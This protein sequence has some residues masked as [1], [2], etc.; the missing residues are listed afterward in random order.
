MTI[1]AP[2]SSDAQPLRAHLL[3]S[4]RL[5]VGD[6][7]V[8]D[9]VWSRRAARSLLLLLLV[10]PGHRLPRDR[11]LEL[12]WPDASPDSADQSLRTA[13]HLLRRV[14]QPALRSGR[15][16]VYLAVNVDVLELNPELVRLD[17]DAFE[18]LLAMARAAAVPERRRLLGQVLG[19]YEGDLLEDEPYVEWAEA[20]RERLRRLHR[21]A[22]L[23]LALLDAE[24]GEPGSSVTELERLLHKDETD[25]PV[26][27]AFMQALAGAGRSDDAVRVYH[28]VTA[29]LRDELGV[30]PDQETRDLLQ[31]IRSAASV[32]SPPPA[33]MIQIRSPA[34][35]PAPPTPIIGRVREAER[36]QDLLLDRDIRL[37]TVT[38]TGGVGKTRLVQEVARQL[39]DDFADG[40]CFVGLAAVYDPLLVLPTIA[41]A[42]GLAESVRYPVE[43]VVGAA[44]Q[45]RDMLL[46]L[47]N[48]EQVLD[49]A[50]HIAVL[51]ERCDDLTILATSREPLRLRAEHEMPLLPLSVPESA[52]ASRPRMV[53]R[54]DAIELF[55]RRAEAVRE[56]FVLTDENSAVLVAL[57]KQLDGLPLAIELAAAQIR[58]MSLEHLLGGLKDRFDLLAGGYRDLPPRQQSLR[59][60]IAWSYDLQPPKRQTLFRALSVFSAGFSPDAAEEVLQHMEKGG[61]IAAPHSNA[62]LSHCRHDILAL[63]ESSLVIRT[64]GEESPR[65]SMM[66]SI[67]EYGLHQ[68]SVNGEAE[69]ARQAHAI[70]CLGLAERAV[71]NL[72]EASQAKW[73]DQ[74]EVE[75]DNMRAALA[76]A[77]QQPHAELALSL[78]STLRRFW[79]VRGYLV[80]G[81]DWLERALAMPGSVEPATRVQAIFAAG[82]LA[83]FL[84][85]ASRARALAEEG[86]VICRSLGD[87]SGAADALLG[88]GHLTR[89][90]GDLHRAEMYL[91]EGIALAE[92]VNDDSLLSMLQEALAH[93]AIEYGNLDLAEALFTNSLELDRRS[94]NVRGE[95][96]S[97]SGL[98]DVS[99]RRGDIERAIEIAE[100]ALGLLRDIRDPFATATVLLRMGALLVTQGDLDRAEALFRE[101]LEESWD[102]RLDALAAEF[103]LAMA[104]SPHTDRERSTYLYAATEAFCRKVGGPLPDWWNERRQSSES[105]SYISRSRSMFPDIWASA[106]ALSPDEVIAVAVGERNA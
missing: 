72:K 13:V 73:L 99:S 79:L 85:D 48:M 75:L 64:E 9:H 59:N 12:L 41:R 25:E 26:L 86:L 106:Q 74:L 53:A 11:V 105:A 15:D 37:V 50:P 71:P 19:L 35:V 93:V 8:P 49:A 47:D 5:S 20:P 84:E 28:Q 23:D 62:R 16:S 68:L 38:G 77:L 91:R 21:R 87:A 24:R 34:S 61:G 66:E 80:E 102:N 4:V 31:D 104:S 33:A 3:G 101:G 83:F 88:L 57:C 39:G 27:R 36:L 56:D 30:E 14:L 89:V 90:A 76:Y 54:Y 42:L 97:L 70:W 6:T 82:E 40:V 60:A 32:A 51:L 2:S 18:D 22:V 43:E 45:G 7:P 81:R 1:D 67:R 10:T 78:A 52:H 100:E 92:S 17:S 44:L 96:S 69:T 63:M 29:S 94:G 95:A 46:V 98:A 55:L 58:T 103:L 65:F